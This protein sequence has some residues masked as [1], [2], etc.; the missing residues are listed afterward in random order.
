MKNDLIT[1]FTSV[2]LSEQT[3]YRPSIYCQLK[4]LE[5]QSPAFEN[6][7]GSN[8]VWGCQIEQI[9]TQN[10]MINLNFR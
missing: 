10:A 8:S 4:L 5:L 3:C 2:H 1:Q 9:E 7:I 6:Q